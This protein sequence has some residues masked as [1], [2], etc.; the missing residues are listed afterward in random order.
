MRQRAFVRL[1]LS[2]EMPP[3]APLCQASTGRAEAND[4]APANA[5]ALGLRIVLSSDGTRHVHVMNDK[6]QV[7]EDAASSSSKRELCG[8]FVDDA[9]ATYPRSQLV[10]AY[11]RW[12]CEAQDPGKVAT[13]HSSQFA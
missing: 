3:L 8:D 7:E 13:S 9:V 2:A 10:G 11:V 1:L 5:A 4:V 12:Q 6:T